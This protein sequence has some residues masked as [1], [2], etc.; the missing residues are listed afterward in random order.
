MEENEFS[1]IDGQYMIS[2]KSW[3]PMIYALYYNKLDIVKHYIDNLQFPIRRSLKIRED[4]LSD[5]KN[6][7]LPFII[8][9]HHNNLDL[10]KYLIS[11]TSFILDEDKIDQML[12][13]HSF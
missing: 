3:S 2:T 9:F 4:W 7:L 10:F 1:N 13:L 5:E 6:K 8:S 12:N 11:E